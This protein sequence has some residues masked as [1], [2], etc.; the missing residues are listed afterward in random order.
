MSYFDAVHGTAVAPRCCRRCGW[1]RRAAREPHDDAVP[2]AHGDA[3][4]E[5]GLILLQL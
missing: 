4:G 5:S 3:A 1:V 2:A